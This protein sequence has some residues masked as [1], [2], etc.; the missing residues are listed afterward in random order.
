MEQGPVLVLT[1]SAQQVMVV[2]DMSGKIIEGDPV[3]NLQSRLKPYHL[4]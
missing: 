3:R 2:R 4:I 1:F